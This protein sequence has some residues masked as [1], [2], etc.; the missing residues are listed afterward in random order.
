M[1]AQAGIQFEPHPPPPTPHPSPLPQGE[2]CKKLA[3]ENFC[4]DGVLR[5]TIRRNVEPHFLSNFSGISLLAKVPQ[6]ER[7]LEAVT[8]GF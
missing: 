5:K 7:G 3:P 4:K 1:P 6:G 2:L 8:P